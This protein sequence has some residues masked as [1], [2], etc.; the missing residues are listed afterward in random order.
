MTT[1]A[2]KLLLL[3]GAQKFSFTAIFYVAEYLLTLQM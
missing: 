2:A 1:D 3:L